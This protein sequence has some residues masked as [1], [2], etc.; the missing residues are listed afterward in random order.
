ML[1]GIVSK[2]AHI[3]SH[4]KALRDDGFDV[5]G[6]GSSPTEVPPTV[7]LL[8][9][10]T[11]S[12]SH[13]GS[14]TA[15]TWSRATKKPLI[16]ENGLSGIRSKL[17]ELFPMYFEYKNSQAVTPEENMPEA[18]FPDTSKFYAALPDFA[19][20]QATWNLRHVPIHRL[21]LAF[22]EALEFYRGLGSENVMGVR[23]FWAANRLSPGSVL[24]PPSL[25]PNFKDLKGRPLSFFIV[26]K[27]CLAKVS[28]EP[29][30]SEFQN[31]YRDFSGAAST[32]SYV[33]AAIWAVENQVA[34]S[35]EEEPS[36]GQSEDRSSPI[37]LGIGGT[38][39]IEPPQKEAPLPQKPQGGDDFA[40]IRSDL[41]DFIL[42]IASQ[43]QELLSLVKTLREEVSSLRQEVSGLR[44]APVSLDP[45]QVLFGLRDK[46]ARITLDL[47][48]KQ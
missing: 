38:C 28:P 41:E 48:D 25:I 15:Y 47:G 45:M 6:L 21:E 27:W 7:D 46:G 32:R 22:K 39:L 30:I 31:M 10:R 9:L 34:F 26:A 33:T 16:V 11:Q 29:T 44:A 24:F 3:K 4:S 2:D 1:I 23:R 35:T 17:R 43:N 20:W 19:E 5:V 13:G 8:V 40:K 36:S 18:K 37:D 42:D 14:N 12:C